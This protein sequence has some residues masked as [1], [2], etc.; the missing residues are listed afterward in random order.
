MLDRTP[1]PVG[2]VMQ[3]ESSAHSSVFGSTKRADSVRADVSESTATGTSSTYVSQRTSQSV[4][5]SA[6]TGLATSHIADDTIGAVIQ[7]SQET[8]TVV[9][10]EP[11]QFE[12]LNALSMSDR[13]LLGAM[14]GYSFSEFGKVTDKNGNAAYPE[15]LTQH[16]LRSF[17]MSLHAA[18]N[19]A[20]AGA[21]AGEDVTVSEFTAM[22][23]QTRATVS[24]MGEWFNED[25]MVKG[26]AYL[27]SL[28]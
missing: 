17:Q 10:S 4:A 2:V 22:M 1:Q 14:T 11:T 16:T 5:A 26:L 12:K 6:V 20:P 9:R 23:A 18:R 27:R 8:N 19:G 21:I 25:Y 28:G 24:S 13:K 3:I 15:D 7:Q